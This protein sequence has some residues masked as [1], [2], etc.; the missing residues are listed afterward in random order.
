MDQVEGTRKDVES[1]QEEN[2]MEYLDSQ[3]TQ[4]FLPNIKGIITHQ[5][6]QRGIHLHPKNHRE[7]QKC[8]YSDIKGKGM[9][10][11]IC[12]ESLGRSSHQHLM[13]KIIWERMLKS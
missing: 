12:K 6:L 11:T 9:R 1:I 8:T 2:T 4:E 3:G 10:K 5:H 7:T 13:V